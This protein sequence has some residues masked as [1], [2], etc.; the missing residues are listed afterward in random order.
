LP[1]DKPESTDSHFR[2]RLGS[3][4][5]FFDHGVVGL[6]LVAS[7]GTI[8][9]ANRAELA[10]LGYDPGEYVG[11]KIQNFHCDAP[12]IEDIL[13]R[14]GRGERLESYPAR[15]RCKNGAVRHV[16]I[17]SSAL[18]REGQ[19]INT[20]CFTVDVTD[21]LEIERELRR[22]QAFLSNILDSTE[23]AFYAVDRDGVTTLCNRA[24]LQMLGFKDQ[25]EAVGRKLHDVIHHSHADGRPYPKHDCPVYCA[26]S[27]GQPAHVEGEVFFRQDGSS[28]P[29]EYRASPLYENGALQGAICTFSD[30]TER[31]QAETA[32]RQQGQA[33][34]DESRAL[35]ILNRASGL[36]AADLDL[37]RLVQTIVDAG[38]EISGA[39]F[40]AFFYNLIDEAGESYTLY[41][42]SGAPR[43]AFDRFPMPRNT[44]VFAPT[45]EGQGPM[46]V[47][48]ILVD[49]RYG[50]N[51][52]YE[53]MPNGHLPVRSYLAVPVRSRTG[54]VL[55]GL[56]FGHAQPGRFDERAETLMT[57]LAGQAAVRSTMRGSSRMLSRRLS[58]VALRRRRY[59]S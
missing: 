37:E 56:F 58:S 25:G 45:F 15:L 12:V 11:Q 51:P 36:V 44:Q 10:L 59:S 4:D 55:G 22:S 49:P 31:V 27:T 48:D 29:V 30:I 57:G 7:D 3:L 18:F 41:A 26:A 35:S 52:P 17:S 5:D 53:G 50:H 6:H 1:S 19:F 40:G 23:E 46:R 47:D 42:L 33:L 32:L 14:L 8:L 24:F 13:A 21:R 9:R 2:E 16:E 28:F 34:A 54:E 39:G 43:E 38:V 20:R